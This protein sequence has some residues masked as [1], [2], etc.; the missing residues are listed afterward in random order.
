MGEACSRWPCR[1]NEGSLPQTID[2]LD[3]GERQNKCF[4]RF[5]MLERYT[6]CL[7]LQASS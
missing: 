1:Y 7:L 3:F 5:L 2:F 4:L 6:P